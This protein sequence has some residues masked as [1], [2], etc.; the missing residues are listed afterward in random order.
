MKNIQFKMKESRIDETVCRELYYFLRERN[1]LF[2][3]VRGDFPSYEEFK[4]TVGNEQISIN[5][6]FR[7]LYALLKKFIN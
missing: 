3:D 4:N 5:P 1:L 2:E 6:A 7:D